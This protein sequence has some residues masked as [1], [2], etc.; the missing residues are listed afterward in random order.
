MMN[1]NIAYNCRTLKRK[2]LIFACFTRDGIV[3]VKKSFLGKSFK[4][5][6]MNILH[7]MFPEFNFNNANRDEGGCPNIINST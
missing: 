7:E 5:H 1:E 2:G 3:H 6:H 4:I